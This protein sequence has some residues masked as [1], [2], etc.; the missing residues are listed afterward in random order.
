MADPGLTGWTSHGHRIPN[1]P[2]TGRPVNVARCGGPGMCNVCSREAAAAPPARN[3]IT[4]PI[5][6]LAG[7]PNLD[8]LG[9][10][11][12]AVA[13]SSRDWSNDGRDG[14]WIYGIV[15]GWDDETDGPDAGDAMTEVA[16]LYR[17]DAS[18]IARLRAL[19]AA[20]KALEASA[21]GETQAPTT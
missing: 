16:S 20:W 8:P 13:F 2:Q 19:H 3:V 17:W 11:H 21:R 5:T 9:A 10:L 6:A 14:A 7:P 4:D 12:D 1:V 18:T 15:C